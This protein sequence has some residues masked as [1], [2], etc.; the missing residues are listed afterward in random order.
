MTLTLDMVKTWVLQ[1]IAVGGPSAVIAYALFRWLG[2][3]WI[4]QKFKAQLEELKH[5]HQKELE[6]VRHEI[7][8]TFSRV[9]KIHEREFEILPK[10]WFM[11]HEAIGMAATAVGL[12]MKYYPEFEKMSDDLF[13][14]FLAN[15]KRM[16]DYQ[17]GQLR[18][19][20]DRSEY[21]QKLTMMLDMDDAKVKNRLLNNYLIEHRIF[22]N[23]EL[24][25][26]F[27]TIV[28]D[29]QQGVSEFSMGKQVHDPQLEHDGMKRISSLQAK[30]PDLEKAVQQR[31]HYGEA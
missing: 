3:K 18:A 6:A 30:M 28:T 11:L 8:K 9:S 13:V 14:E 22:M 31:L 19:A 25:E 29:L 16:S 27:S 24:Q 26:R 21:Y 20:Q 7:Q 23:A 5:E 1:V 4:E 2:E 10:A 12:I 15:D 17:K